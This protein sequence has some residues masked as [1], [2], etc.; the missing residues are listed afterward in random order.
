MEPR[1]A[2]G[3]PSV[4]RETARQVDPGQAPDSF[5][6]WRLEGPSLDDEGGLPS[7]HADRLMALGSMVTEIAHEINNLLSPILVYSD[8]AH[9][10]K[11]K[12]EIKSKAL[13]V[14]QHC[15]KH[16][17]LY[18][19]SIMDLARPYYDP[20]EAGHKPA[21]EPGDGVVSCDLPSIWAKVELLLAPELRR[22]DVELTQ[23][24]EIEPVNMSEVH[25]HQML[26]NLTS[27]AARSLPD[28]GGKISVSSSLKTVKDINPS[29]I[30]EFADNGP[31]L[32]E[33]IRKAVF[34]AEDEGGD[35]SSLPREVAGHGFGL[36]ICR[37]L[38][39]RWGGEL[40]YC[41]RDEPGAVFQLIL[42]S[43]AKPLSR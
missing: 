1:H 10:P 8:L 18:L 5:D 40:V 2:A 41:P 17:A 4:D 38:A 42:P 24:F 13:Q 11:A 25:L 23:S 36:R 12:E 3:E 32:P 16:A 31:G 39:R 22:R 19:E 27:N 29:L 21:S 43:D 14:T 6:P 9:R 33:E 28:Q 35:L 34:E 15:A 26:L 37:R 7:A 20:A 30:V